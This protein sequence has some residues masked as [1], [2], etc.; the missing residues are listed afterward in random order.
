MQ[1]SFKEVVNLQQAIVERDEIMQELAYLKRK[2]IEK[3]GPP[4]LAK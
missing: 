1:Q 4:G 2:S 3:W